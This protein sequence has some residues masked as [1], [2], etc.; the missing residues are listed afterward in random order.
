MSERSKLQFDDASISVM[1]CVAG[2]VQSN[3]HDKLPGR[4][5]CYSGLLWFC[6]GLRLHASAA[7]F[8]SSAS[9]TSSIVSFPTQ[10]TISQSTFSHST[11]TTF[12]QSNPTISP[13]STVCPREPLSSF[14]S[15]F[16]AS[17]SAASP[18]HRCCTCNH[19]SSGCS[20]S[21]KPHMEGRPKSGYCPAVCHK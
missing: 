4:P 12:S 16:P 17:S 10:D 14:A 15:S 18:F 5:S 7:T 2:S 21:V 11:H 20:S 8:S 1:F 6:T 19:T 9:S 13:I 3:C